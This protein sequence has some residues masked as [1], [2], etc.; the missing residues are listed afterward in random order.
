MER[1]P[2]ILASHAVADGAHL[3]SAGV[4]TRALVK[5]GKELGLIKN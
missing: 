2:L 4:L 3:S 1:I 5:A